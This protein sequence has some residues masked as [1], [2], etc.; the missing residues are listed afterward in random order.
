MNSMIL[1]AV[2]AVSTLTSPALAQSPPATDVPAPQPGV[3]APAVVPGA[4][5]T[6]LTDRDRQFVVSALEANVAELN[7]A[8]LA[9]QHSQNENVRGFAQKMITDHTYP[10]DTLTP[11]ASMHHIQ[12]PSMPTDAHRD[13]VDRLSKLYGP[14]FDRSYVNDMA[15]MNALMISDFNT[16]V[17]KVIDPHIGAWVQNIRPML[18]QHS[19]ITQQLLT[20][21]P[22]TG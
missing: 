10:Q 9:L 8:Q 12:A 4:P 19:E 1:P 6:A 21:L 7:A 15:N 22:Y 3:N 13:M 2:L 18:L 5:V 17:M 11:I 14:A 20:S 16:E